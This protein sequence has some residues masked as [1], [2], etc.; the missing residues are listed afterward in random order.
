MK[1]GVKRFTSMA[2]AAVLTM[3]SAPV[4]ASY[5]DS[6]YDPPVDFEEVSGSD[7]YYDPPA[8]NTYDN[9]GGYDASDYVDFEE[10]SGSAYYGDGG[11]YGDEGY[12]AGQ[13][14][15]FS[16]AGYETPQEPADYENQQESGEP[17]PET[18]QEQPPQGET[19]AILRSSQGEQFFDDFAKAWDAATAAAAVQDAAYLE[20]LADWTSDENGVFGT[21]AAFNLEGGLCLDTPDGSVTII[22]NGHTI[23]S[24]APVIPGGC[25]IC[26]YHG[27]LEIQN[28]VISGGNSTTDGGGILVQNGNLI[29][30]HATLAGNAAQNGAGLCVNSGSA[31]I[32]DSIIEGLILMIVYCIGMGI[33]FVISSILIDKLK[34]VFSFIKKNYRYVKI[35]SGIILMVM[36]IYLIFF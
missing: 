14:V 8:E 34:N 23:R 32:K 15:D 22:G 12:D 20:L 18:P 9:S 6:Y 21:S 17:N 26:L 7:Y 36:G 29:L 35:F 1:S 4:H 30:D 16:G 2:L 5:A 33:P 27:T 24:Q 11:Y 3:T 25:V 10:P 13:Y 31:V 28:T 19:V